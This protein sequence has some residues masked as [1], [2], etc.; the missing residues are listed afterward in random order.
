M[1]ALAR[2]LEIDF[3][4]SRDFEYFEYEHARRFAE[5][6]KTISAQ[7]QKGIEGDLFDEPRPLSDGKP[8]LASAID[9]QHIYGKIAGRVYTNAYAAESVVFSVRSA[10]DRQDDLAEVG[11]RPALEP[12]VR[13][14]AG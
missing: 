3:L 13:P 9:I 11:A 1:L 5:H 10:R 14:A 7:S 2:V 8:S 12:L 4:N 6:G